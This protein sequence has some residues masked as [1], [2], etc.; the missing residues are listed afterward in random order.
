MTQDFRSTFSNLFVSL[1]FLN[2]RLSGHSSVAN[3]YNFLFVVLSCNVLASPRT[4]FV[5]FAGPVATLD[6]FGLLFLNAIHVATNARPFSHAHIAASCV[7]EVVNH[8]QRTHSM[9]SQLLLPQLEATGRV[10]FKIYSQSSLPSQKYSQLE[11]SLKFPDLTAIQNLRIH[12]YFFYLLSAHI[13][14]GAG[15]KANLEK[16]KDL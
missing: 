10:E 16:S 6:S 2:H 1:L 11:A 4:Y 13:R 12:R 3:W 15:M 5:N 8:P 14:V 7:F 9:I